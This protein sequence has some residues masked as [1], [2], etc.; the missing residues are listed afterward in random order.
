MTAN[1]SARWGERSVEQRGQE[2][3]AVVLPATAVVGGAYYRVRV[4]NVAL[5]GAMFETSAL[6]PVRS[7]LIF[8]CGTVAASATVEWQ[9]GGCVGVR[10]D[11]LLH[12]REVTEQRSRSAAVAARSEGLSG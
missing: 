11:R 12:D 3:F 9:S 8:R 5:G 1:S 4:I 7:K 6:M 2:R 10:F